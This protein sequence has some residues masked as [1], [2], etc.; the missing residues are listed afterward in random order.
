M[1]FEQFARERLPALLR[2]TT[3]MCADPWLAEDVVQEVLVRVHARWSHIEEFGAPEAYVR[4]ALVN[5]YLSWRRKWARI[6][7]YAV[8]PERE[9][10]SSDAAE[11]QATR[12]QLASEL[13]ALPARQ[14]AAL[15]MRYYADM[16]DDEIASDFGCRA[17]SV[18]GYISRGLAALRVQVVEA[19]ITPI[20]SDHA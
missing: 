20:R 7:P 5:E 6:V 3:A 17:V 15:V 19:A 8:L 16:S 18:R 1:E 9:R 11:Q 12:S 2:F 10:V 13:A 4:R 14:R